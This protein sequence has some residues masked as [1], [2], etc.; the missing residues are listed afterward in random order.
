MTK[1]IRRR[2]VF[3]NTRSSESLVSQ[4]VTMDA[5]H[6]IKVRHAISL[7][8]PVNLAVKT[9]FGTVS[10]TITAVVAVI[11]LVTERLGTALAL[12]MIH[13]TETH[14]IANAVKNVSLQLDD[15]VMKQM[16]IV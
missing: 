15:L 13:T 9:G 2:A 4:L 16:D 11:L 12:V 1:I 6:K 5:L 8:E 10:V 7:M 14:V 3:A